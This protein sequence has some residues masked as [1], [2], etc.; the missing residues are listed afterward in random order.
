MEEPTREELL[1]QQKDLL[2]IIAYLGRLARRLKCEAVAETAQDYLE[3]W[4]ERR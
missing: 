2:E 4:S 3:D 1:R